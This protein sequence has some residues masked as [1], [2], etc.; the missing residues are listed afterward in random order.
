M[1]RL[2]FGEAGP[3]WAR[4]GVAAVLVALCL[5]TSQPGSADARTRRAAGVGSPGLYRA[6]I[7]P[8]VVL[9]PFNPPTDRFGA[10]TVG[11]DLAADTGAKIVTAGSGIV[12][13][14]GPVAG[15]GVVVVTHPDGIR[16]EYEPLRPLVVVGQVVALGNVIGVIRGRHVGC[17]ASCLHWGARRGDAY[18]DPLSL[19]HPLGPVRLLPW[20]R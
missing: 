9:H 13:F 6:P 17:A 12:A 19:L 15:R 10:G 18:F 2:T 4:R 11:V 5:G 8:L 16:T 3:A 1:R 7:L 20:P 14:A